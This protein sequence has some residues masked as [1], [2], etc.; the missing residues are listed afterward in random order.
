MQIDGVAAMTAALGALSS[1]Q[2]YNPNKRGNVSVGTG[3]YRSSSAMAVGGSYYT[4]KNSK[5][6]VNVA[7]GSNTATSIGAGFSLGF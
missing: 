3:V 7:F 6:A 5:I 2:V 4:T 1:S